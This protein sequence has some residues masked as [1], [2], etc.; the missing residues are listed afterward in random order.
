[1]FPRR[2]HPDHFFG[3]LGLLQKHLEHLMTEY[4]LQLFKLQRRCNTKHSSI[5]IEAP[6]RPEDVAVGIESEK[7]AAVEVIAN[8]LFD[9]RTPET[10]LSGKTVIIDLHEGFKV[11]LH[12]VIIVCILWLSRAVFFCR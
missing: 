8:D 10:V 12:A 2:Q 4:G 9:I 1:M 7:V 5:A 11:I 3:D 6:V